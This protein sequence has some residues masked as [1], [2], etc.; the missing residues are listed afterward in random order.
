[1]SQLNLSPDPIVIGAQAAIF[2][3]NMYVVKKLI[4]EPYLSV[5]ARR[6]ARTGGNQDAAQKL[7]QESQALEAKIT[8]RMRAAH[9]EAATARDAIK[10]EA[11]TKRSA[12]LSR[13]DAAAKSEQAQI[14]AEITANLNSERAKKE[15]TI[16][17]IA[18]SFFAQAVH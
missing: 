7:S 4:L 15:E 13:A 5:R 10:N 2:L 6:E 11:I 12:T 3:A 9:K 18:D 1:M 16:K 8:E 14:D 17:T